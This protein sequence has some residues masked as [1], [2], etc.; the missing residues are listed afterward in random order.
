MVAYP[1]SHLKMISASKNTMSCELT[2]RQRNISQRLLYGQ[3]GALKKALILYEWLS[4]SPTGEIEESNSFFSCA[5][6]KIGE[7]FSLLTECIFA[8][9]RSEG[10]SEYVTKKM[11]LLDERLTSGVDLKGPGQ[12]GLRIRGFGGGY[13]SR[14]VQH[15]YFTSQALGQLWV[16]ELE[17]FLFGGLAQKVVEEISGFGK[18]SSSIAPGE[19]GNKSRVMEVQASTSRAILTVDRNHPGTV[20][21]HGKTVRLTSK[22]FWL[23]AVLAES[24]GKCV[25][26]DVIYEKV[27][28]GEVVVEMQQISYHKAQLLRKFSTVAPIVEVKGLITAVSGEGLVLVLNP[29][30]VSLV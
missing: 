25:P 13:I 15:G 7:E 24:P 10:W 9:P 29:S 22:Q 1:P 30:E 11:D 4:S 23:L 17:Q 5:I 2:L 27:W 19:N 26:Y 3:E 21:Y 20:E 14:L 16:E 6:K 18:Q 28:G 12:S 8:L